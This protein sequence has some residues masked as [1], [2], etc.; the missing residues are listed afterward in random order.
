MHVQRFAS[1]IVAVSGW[2]SEIIVQMGHLGAIFT[3]CSTFIL[4]G[5]YG[6]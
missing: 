2:A 3:I 5:W 6:S 1:V 4:L